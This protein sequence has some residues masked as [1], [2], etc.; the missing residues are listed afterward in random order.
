MT[1]NKIKTIKIDQFDGGITRDLRM[2]SHN[3]FKITKN[4]D[5]FSDSKRL[6]PYR[7]LIANETKNINITQFLQVNSQIYGYGVVVGYAI[8]KIYKKTDT[9][10]LI[11]DNWTEDRNVE[12][13][14]AREGFIF[15]HY[16]NYLYFWEAGER[17]SRHGDITGI[18]TNETYQ[19]ITYT[20]V[21]QPV[22]H[23][24]DDI[25]YFFSDNKVH[26]LDNTSW[27]LA[28]LT[29]PDNLIITS[30]CAYGNYLAIGCKSKELTGHS[31]VFLWDRD[32]SLTTISDKIDWGE[33][34]LMI[35][36]VLEGL[37]V[38]ISN[39]STKFFGLKPKI[40]IKGYSG[41]LS[42]IQELDV[43]SATTGDEDYKIASGAKVVKNGKLYFSVHSGVSANAKNY[44]G[45]WVVGRHEIG[46][47]FAVTMAY[48]IDTD[49]SA[50]QI[51]GFNIFDDYL[52]VAHSADGSVDRTN[53]ND[54]YATAI[55][56]SYIF[57]GDSS[58]QTKKLL[59]AKVTVEPQS[60]GGTFTLKYK[61]DAE[62]TWTTIFT[63]STDG[64]IRHT[65]LNIESSGANLGLFKEVQFRIESTNGTVITSIEFE[66]EEIDD[67][68]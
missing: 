66:F 59:R 4:F 61:R 46:S 45:I 51:Q 56:E 54:A 38:G 49:A 22:H 64:Q 7:N 3:K 11:T 67:D 32:S 43:D 23:P 37:L 13:A 15:F 16:K 65:A 33:G 20:N 21:A 52:F 26:K 18:A 55:Y 27:S 2:Q 17:L 57:N 42:F 14:G 68:K 5:I 25:A 44:T 30:A 48:K 31:V 10:S 6:Q 19:T 41:S 8:A 40:H 60:T 50:D 1:Q 35:L 62:T 28:V 39:V 24:A 58:L 63:D 12:G 9:S 47:P 36:E 34:D 29:L 53:N